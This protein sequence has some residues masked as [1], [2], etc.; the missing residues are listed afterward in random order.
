MNMITLIMIGKG[1]EMVK[2]M[3]LREEK[4]MTSKKTVK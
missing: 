2:G 3:K 1:G 4:Y